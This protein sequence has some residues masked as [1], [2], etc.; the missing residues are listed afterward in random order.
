MEGSAHGGESEAAAA[1]LTASSAQSHTPAGTPASA[2]IPS[3]GAPVNSPKKK[4]VPPHEPC[5]YAIANV[6]DI[7]YEFVCTRACLRVLA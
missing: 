5:F 6:H 3:T 1:T 2:G 7:K 4:E